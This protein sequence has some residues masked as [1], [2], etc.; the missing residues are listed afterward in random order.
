MN[1]RQL[2]AEDAEVYQQLRLRCERARCALRESGVNIRNDSAIALYRSLGF[3]THG[4]ERGYL[5]ID[6]VLHDEH[7]MGRRIGAW[8]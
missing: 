2:V 1:I 4:I 5:L 6:G 3:V 7:F 8:Q